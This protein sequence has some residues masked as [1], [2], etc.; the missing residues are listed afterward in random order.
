[1]K[2]IKLVADLHVHTISSGH[3]YSTFEE[4]V[5]HAKKIGLK[6]FAITDHGPKMPGGPHYYHFSNLRMIPDVM[7]GIRIYKGAE[8]NI[9]N[10]KGEI[11]LPFDV[12]AELDIVMVAFHPRVGYGGGDEG[13]NTEVLFRALKNPYVNVIAHPGN[14]MYPLNP[15]K[16]VAEAKKRGV[17]IEINNSSFTGSRTGSWGRCLEFAREIKKQDWLL[18]VGSDS[19]ISTMLGTKEKAMKLLREAGIGEREVVNTSLQ[20]ID[21]YLIRR[22]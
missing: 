14:P 15:Q 17:V 11:D 1:M 7:N 19:H 6:A 20:K 13:K 21:K 3:A 9:I 8:C 12:L 22:K 10:D 18:T 2:N 16:T 4:Y 5:A